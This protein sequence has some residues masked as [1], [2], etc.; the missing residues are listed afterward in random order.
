M[1]SPKTI[2]LEFLE[3]EEFYALRT[4]AQAKRRTKARPHREPEGFSK[5]GGE[6]NFS[7]RL[8]HRIFTVRQQDFHRR[9]V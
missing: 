9:P 7:W 8:V 6:K 1:L 2:A 5:G 4:A 3:R